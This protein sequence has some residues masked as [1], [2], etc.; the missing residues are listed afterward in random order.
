MDFISIVP[1][2]RSMVSQQETLASQHEREWA[3][4]EAD[5]KHRERVRELTRK[6]HS[7]LSLWIPARFRKPRP[8]PAESLEPKPTTIQWAD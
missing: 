5:R 8:A 3:A 6:R 7:E 2:Y 4:R 1:L